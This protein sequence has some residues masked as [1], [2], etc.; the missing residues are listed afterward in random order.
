[1]G[2]GAAPTVNIVWIT[3]WTAVQRHHTVGDSTFH[4]DV[5]QTWSVD[6]VFNMKIIQGDIEGGGGG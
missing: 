3:L 1:M 6:G 5:G 2:V 4:S